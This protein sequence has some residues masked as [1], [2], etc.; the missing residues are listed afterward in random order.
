MLK[1]HFFNDCVLGTT[2]INFYIRTRFC[3]YLICRKETRI[4]SN[5]LPFQIFKKRLFFAADW[6]ISVK[7]E[8]RLYFSIIVFS[9]KRLKNWSVIFFFITDLRS[10]MDTIFHCL[11]ILMHESKNSMLSLLFSWTEIP[12]DFRL[13]SDWLRIV[14]YRVLPRYS[15]MY[16]L[17]SNYWCY[18]A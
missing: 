5:Q 12:D 1:R 14:G 9:V 4:K 8:F 7:S 15:G 2:K 18:S 17:Q 13:G 16:S 10:L 6:I 11:L 3:W